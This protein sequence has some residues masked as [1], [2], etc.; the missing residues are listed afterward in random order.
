MV[1]KQV[2]DSM[3]KT[4]QSVLLKVKG[5]IGKLSMLVDTQALV[6]QLDD[7]QVF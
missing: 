3:V 6:S 2:H 4:V 5:S 1:K 7:G